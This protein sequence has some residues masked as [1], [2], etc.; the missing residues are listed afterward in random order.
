MT[1]TIIALLIVAAAVI[2]V[3]HRVVRL[4]KGKGGGGCGCKDCP[5]KGRTDC[6]CNTSVNLPDI[7][8]DRL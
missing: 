4:G 7:D 1:Q 2:F 5:M 3:V 6:T 8:P